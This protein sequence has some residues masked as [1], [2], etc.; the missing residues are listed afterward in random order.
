[1]LL[2]LARRMYLGLPNCRGGG[3]G[4]RMLLTGTPLR[5]EF[6]RLDREEMRAAM[7]L[8]PQGPVVLVTG[9]SQGAQVLN[10]LVPEALAQLDP[11]VQVLHLTGLGA[12]DGVRRAYNACA[13]RGLRAHVRPV[14][15]D[16]HRMFGA[17]DLVICRGG[18]STVAELMAAGRPAVVVPYPHHRD[19]QQFHNAEVLSRAGAGIVVEEAGLNAKDLAARVGELLAQPEKL[20]EMGRQA[21]LLALVDPCGAILADLDRE[22]GLR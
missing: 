10:R 13:D 15:M 21:R 8:R 9:G 14:A 7:G 22:V 4:S 11:P 12:D 6:Y 5:P 2:P 18:G 19:R 20:A 1:M 17:A 3:T 16:M